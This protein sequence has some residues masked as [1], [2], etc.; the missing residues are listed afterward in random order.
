MH[1]STEMGQNTA[2]QTQHS[3]LTVPTQ[4]TGSGAP[5]TPFAAPKAAPVPVLPHGCCTPQHHTL[6]PDEV[7]LSYSHN[8]S[9]TVAD[10]HSSLSGWGG[11]H[12]FY[13]SMAIL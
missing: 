11:V 3:V 5:L 9:D 2:H 4:N 12:S 6:S 8:T 13:S 1:I 10:R 7:G